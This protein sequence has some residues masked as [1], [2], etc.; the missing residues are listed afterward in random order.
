MTGRANTGQNKLLASARSLNG[1]LFSSFANWLS[2]INQ[3]NPYWYATLTPTARKM[4]ISDLFHFIAGASG[5]MALVML[6][7]SEDDE[8]FTVETDPRSSDFMLLKKGNLRIDPWQTKKSHVVFLAK[9][10]P[11]LGGVKKENGDIVEF[12]VDRDDKSRLELFWQYM[13]NKF[14]PG[15][16]NLIQYGDKTELKEYSGIEF[17]ED[18]FGNDYKAEKMF[19]PLYIQ[20]L[21]EVAKEQPNTLGKTVSFLNYLGLINTQIYGEDTRGVKDRPDFDENGNKTV[22]SEKF[23]Y[24]KTPSLPKPPSIGR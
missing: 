20:S 18:R 11:Y 8:Q 9:V 7:S 2:V 23:S 10:F 16:S 14:S 1:T 12:G 4:A 19:I 6:A 24:P 13:S 3:L 5:F 21:K 15:V 17:R 22:K